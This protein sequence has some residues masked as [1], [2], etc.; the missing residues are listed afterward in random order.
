MGV[1]W[2]GA[3]GSGWRAD[4]EESLRDG[5]QEVCVEGFGFVEVDEV[6]RGELESLAAVCARQAAEFLGEGVV[7]DE[8]LAG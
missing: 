1:G 3:V 7:A 5:A 8:L 2:Q 6:G 4:V